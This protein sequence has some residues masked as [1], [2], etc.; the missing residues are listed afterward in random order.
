MEYALK[1][2]NPD[3]K[4][5]RERFPLDEMALKKIQNYDSFQLQE[6]VYAHYEIN[7]FVKGEEQRSRRRTR[8]PLLKDFS[9]SNFRDEVDVFLLFDSFQRSFFPKQLSESF[10]QTIYC[11]F[12][13][14]V[15]K[16]DY[17]AWAMEKQ[18][19]L[20]E[21]LSPK[22]AEWELPQLTKIAVV[23]AIPFDKLSFPVL[24]ALGTNA[25][26]QILK[27]K[28]KQK[29]ELV[30]MSDVSRSK[31]M[32]KFVEECSLAEEKQPKSNDT[33]REYIEEQF[34]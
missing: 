13:E 26:A 2:D 20:P 1:S 31:L 23:K 4:K 9:L 6:I 34:S 21:Y 29:K 33:I 14:I 5:F 17:V 16:S 25:I 30:K 8:V 22:V 10:P 12:N 11:G 24:I 7:P 15:K 28:A 27:R 3:L 18:L 32:A 19:P